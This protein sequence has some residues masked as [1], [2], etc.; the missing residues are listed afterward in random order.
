MR[1]NDDD[2]V[3]SLAAYVEARPNVHDLSPRD[4]RAMLKSRLPPYMIPASIQLIDQLPRLPNLK[5]DRSKL[6]EIDAGRAKATLDHHGLLAPTSDETALWLQAV[7]KKLLRL[8]ILPSLEVSFF[9]LG[10]D[11]L[12]AAELISAVEEKFCCE[13]PL[14]AFLSLQRWQC[15]VSC[16][17]T[18][19]ARQARI[20]HATS[21]KHDCFE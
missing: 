4:L 3:R 2:S 21:R 7:W 13:L 9:E 19:G 5:V 10:G 1:K 16:F 6:A 17:E 11:S 20:Q 12:A 18:R 8:S 14:Q 15:Y